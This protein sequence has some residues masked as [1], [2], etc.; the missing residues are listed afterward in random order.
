MDPT[1]A[2]NLVGDAADGQERGLR[3]Q[4]R[5]KGAH[6]LDPVQAAFMGQFTQGPVDRHAGDPQSFY[7][8]VFRRDAIVGWPGLALDQVQD[9]RFDFLV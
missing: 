7:Q 8:G 4:G 2:S 3:L 6:T 1:T 9:I 5:D